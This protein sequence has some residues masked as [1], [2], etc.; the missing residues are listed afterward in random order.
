MTSDDFYSESKN[1]A[2]IIQYGV[3]NDHKDFIN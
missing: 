2:N 3:G 1:S